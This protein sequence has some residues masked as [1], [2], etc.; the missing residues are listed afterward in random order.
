MGQ[1]RSPGLK[2]RN[3]RRNTRARFGKQEVQV[4][5]TMPINGGETGVAAGEPGAMTESCARRKWRVV[6]AGCA[7]LLCAIGL[8]GCGPV[9]TVEVVQSAVGYEGGGCSITVNALNVT[10]NTTYGIGMFTTGSPVDL[11]ELT[12]NSSGLIVQG[13]VSYPS[14]TLPREYSNL[15]VELYIVHSGQLG[16]GLASVKVTLS[17]CLPTGLAP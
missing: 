16:S 11:G 5:Q 6:T 9:P 2:R 4:Y 17:V 1:R 7:G 12:S 3:E 8:A 14:E 15:Y 13:I 10:P